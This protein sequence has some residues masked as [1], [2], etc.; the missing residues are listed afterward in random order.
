MTENEL[1]KLKRVELLEIML[2][3]GKEI[4]RLKQ[5]VAEQQAQLEDRAIKIEK[6]GTIAEASFALNGI[7]EAAEKTASQYLENIK[8]LNDRQESI[9]NARINETEIKCS[10]LEM[11]T[12]E[13]VDY[14]KEEAQRY[15]SDLRLKTERECKEMRAET[16]AQIAKTDE[17]IAVREAEC[18]TKCDAMKLRTDAECEKLRKDADDYYADKIMRAEADVEKRWEA[19]SKRLEEFYNAHQGLRELLKSDGQVSRLG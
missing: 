12:R 11:S 1:K 9:C 8:T 4:D 13:R 15:C 10:A 7:L 14:M 3:Q 19:L 2:E 5:V 16:D 17:I 6:A 18:K